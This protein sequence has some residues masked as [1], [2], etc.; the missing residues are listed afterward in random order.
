M[1]LSLVVPAGFCIAFINVGLPP[2]WSLA[3]ALVFA[4]VANGLFGASV[5]LVQERQ[6]GVLRRLRVTPI[7]AVDIVAAVVFSGVVVFA[8]CFFLLAMGME[9][10]SGAGSLGDASAVFALLVS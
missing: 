2:A 7:T 8:P 4:I 9:I 1:L 3:T 10:A 6:V 5:R